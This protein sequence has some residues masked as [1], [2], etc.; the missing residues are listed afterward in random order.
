MNLCFRDCGLN[1]FVLVYLDDILVFS[2]SAQEHLQHVERVLQQL[3][4]DQ[5]KAKRK[6]CEFAKVE[7][8]YLGHVVGGGRV[9]V[10]P[11]KTEAV[12]TWPAPTTVREL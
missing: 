1:T 7:A 10:D 11:A 3:R 4:K 5:W 2:E 9:Q 12:A 8:K 6:K